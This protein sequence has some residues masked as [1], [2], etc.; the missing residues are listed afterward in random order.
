[1]NTKNADGLKAH[2][3]VDAECEVRMSEVSLADVS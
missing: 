3:F 1:M 2:V